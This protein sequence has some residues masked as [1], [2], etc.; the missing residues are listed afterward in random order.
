M[1]RA[2]NDLSYTALVAPADGTIAEVHAQK[3][4]VVMAGTPM[5]RLAQGGEPEIQVDVPENR[6]ARIKQT[7]PAKVQWSTLKHH[8]ALKLEQ[9]QCNQLKKFE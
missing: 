7:Q 4:Q 2:Q 1:K 9:V 5:F 3:G 6:I 8:Y